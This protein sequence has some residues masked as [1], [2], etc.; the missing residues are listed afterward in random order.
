MKKLPVSKFFSF[1]AGVIDTGEKPLIFIYLCKNF[2]KNLNRPQWD[3]PG[4]GET[5]SSKKPAIE[6][7][8]SEK[9]IYVYL[10]TGLDVANN[11]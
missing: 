4:L 8:M 3:T 2:C 6:N 7:L 11:L 9:N 1:I 5:Y 10:T